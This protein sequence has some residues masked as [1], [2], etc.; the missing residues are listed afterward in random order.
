MAGLTHWQ[1]SHK[2]WN[3]TR[4]TWR[5]QSTQSGTTEPGSVAEGCWGAGTASAG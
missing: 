2:T 3:M 4:K 5:P 1:R